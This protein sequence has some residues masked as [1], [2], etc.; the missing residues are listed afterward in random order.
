MHI[1]EAVEI[2]VN[3]H[4]CRMSIV[5]KLLERA[6]T[7]HVPFTP[8]DFCGAFLAGRAADLMGQVREALGRM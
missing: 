3:S 5:P 1:F 8:N 4:F 6:F 7:G 2:A